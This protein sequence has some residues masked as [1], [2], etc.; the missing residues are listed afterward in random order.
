M[1]IF[2]SAGQ[3]LRS[4]W[5]TLSQY[6]LQTSW[7][8]NDSL[9]DPNTYAHSEVLGGQ[10]SSHREHSNGIS[11]NGQCSCCIEFNDHKIWKMLICNCEKVFACIYFHLYMY[12]C[13][14]V[15]VKKCR[16]CNKETILDVFE[17][18]VCKS[19][20]VHVNVAFGELKCTHTVWKG[21]G[22]NDWFQVQPL[23]DIV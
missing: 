14:H 21:G 19:P 4:L 2:R 5:K 17:W 1:L 20:C 8:H 11:C 16:L 3:S 18:A 13:I 22:K 7:I 10:R 12:M 9:R 23:V 15:S 6:F